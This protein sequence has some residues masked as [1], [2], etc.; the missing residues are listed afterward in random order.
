MPGLRGRRLSVAEASAF[1][2]EKLELLEGQVS[3]DKRMLLLLLTSFGLRRT[4]ALVGYD[5]W[6][7][8]LSEAKGP[9]DEEGD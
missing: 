8:A 4:A 3:G 6:R 1:A 2:P 7:R 9:E 5:L